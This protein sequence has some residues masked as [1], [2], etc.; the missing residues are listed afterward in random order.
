MHHSV[1]QN[2]CKCRPMIAP[3][4]VFASARKKEGA[5]AALSTDSLRIIEVQENII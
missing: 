1:L 4:I 5:S 2:S 3:Q